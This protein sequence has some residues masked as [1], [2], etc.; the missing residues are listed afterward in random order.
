MNTYTR[1]RVIT[2]LSAALE[3]F[4]FTLLIFLAPVLAVNF[5]PEE[6][7]FG[8]IM[9]VLMLFFAGYLARFFG[10]MIFSHA[11]DR[12]GRKKYYQWSIILMSASTL[13]IAILPNY[14]SWGITATL[15]LFLLRLIQGL[16]L[17][18]EIP[19]AVV[20]SSEHC[21]GNRRGLV[22]GLIICG[23][24][25]GNILASG[26]VWLLYSVF[27]EQAVQ[28]WAWRLAFLTGSS[29]GLVSFWLRR[30]LNE[31]PAYLQ[32]QQHRKQLQS[33]FKATIKQYRGALYK[34]T[35]LAAVPA[36]FVS[37]LLYLP[38]YQQKFLSLSVS[39]TYL[40]SSTVFILLTLLTPLA[41]RLSDR[42]GRLPL[43]KAGSF[44]LIP[45]AF[46]YIFIL[47]ST[48]TELAIWII[49]ILIIIA[50]SLIMGIYE[51]A[52]IELFP[53]EARYS[54]VAFCHNLAFALFGGVT[55]IVLEWLCSRGILFAPGLLIS[56]FALKLLILSY[57]WHDRYQLSLQKI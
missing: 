37:V 29:L 33:P 1:L 11:G 23:V 36:V 57:Y 14:N 55:P 30:S 56:L 17:G 46:L 35:F 18:G 22:T 49:F 2:T 6:S 21:P 31:T 7:G 8:S 3:F 44:L 15:L 19:G 41:A 28:E 54:G 9:P 43:M 25:S 39:N 34:G 51:V 26:F 24:T 32:M 47:N 4:D 38:H 40:T 16:S 53:T 10:G 48:Y 42:S 52:I 13:G 5:F 12:Y 50:M 20:F 27:S 45:T